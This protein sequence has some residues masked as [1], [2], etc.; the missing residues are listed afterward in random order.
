MSKLETIISYPTFGR[1]LI[2]SNTLNMSFGLY[3]L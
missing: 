2:A 3:N 1:H